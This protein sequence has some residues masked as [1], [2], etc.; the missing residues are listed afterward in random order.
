PGQLPTLL[1]LVLDETT[2]TLNTDLT[3]R[4]NIN[5][6]PQ[7]V[8]EA[9]EGVLGG[10]ASPAPDGTTAAPTDTSAQ[11]T[12][13]DIQMIMNTRPDPS[14][15]EPPDASFQTPAWLMTEANFPV[16]KLKALEPYIT[17]R[18]QVYRFQS[19][20]YF[21]GASGPVARIE[22]VIDGNNGAPRIVYH[23]DLTPLGA[24]FD[25][26]QLMGGQ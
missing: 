20:G 6:A 7:T 8:L 10:S 14:A 24:G 12:D 3:P 16:S 11:L 21:Q 5:T 18:S 9:L 17:T 23:R 2:T 22:A 15:G 13:E 19:I 4:I 26:N 1:P 25:M